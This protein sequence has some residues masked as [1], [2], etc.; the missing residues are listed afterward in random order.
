MRATEW[1]SRRGWA[2][3]LTNGLA[4]KTA[5]PQSQEAG[6]GSEPG[7]EG[8]QDPWLGRQRWIGSSVSADGG[9]EVV[10]VTPVTQGERLAIASLSGK[11]R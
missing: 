9:H 4:P 7:G 2:G 1:R 3:S 5:V 8:F 11:K 10:E 6:A